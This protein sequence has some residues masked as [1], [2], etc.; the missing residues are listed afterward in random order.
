MLQK[1]WNKLVSFFKPKTKAEDLTY[2]DI[3]DVHKQVKE[4]ET[5]FTPK[6]QSRRG[7]RSTDLGMRKLRR[8]RSGRQH[9]KRL[10]IDHNKKMTDI[11][12]DEPKKRKR[13]SW[14]EDRE[15]MQ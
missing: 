2:Q 13:R 7:I 3:V 8:H 9:E 14:A 15:R 10:G 11:G 12:D 5:T 1:W 6:P 4:F